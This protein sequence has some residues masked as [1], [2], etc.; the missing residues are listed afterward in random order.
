MCLI[1]FK[2]QLKKHSCK[3]LGFLDPMLLPPFR[4]SSWDVTLQKLYAL[5]HRG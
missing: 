1:S 2:K 5:K 3:G 4:L